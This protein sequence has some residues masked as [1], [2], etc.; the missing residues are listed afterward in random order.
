MYLRFILATIF[1]LSFGSAEAQS[2]KDKLI[3]Q[4][5][6]QAGYLILPS[7]DR[8]RYIDP[9][10]GSTETEAQTTQGL[11]YEISVVARLRYNILEIN[12]DQSVGI[13]IVPA[14]SYIGQG[15]KAGSTSGSS[16]GVNIPIE[17]SYNLGAGSTYNSAK[18]YGFSVHTGV[19][20]SIPDLFISRKNVNEDYYSESLKNFYTLP[21]I[22]LG[23]SYWGNKGTKLHEIFIRAEFGNNQHSDDS[24][25]AEK[26]VKSFGVRAAFVKYIGY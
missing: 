15:S 14:L 5:G 10:S 17:V 23:V 26:A 24:K 2:I 4:W 13:G 7:Y 22:G 16:L 3:S 25:N 8:L 20:F 19:D 12:D 9:F 1:L 6:Y 18:D 11:L 21:Y